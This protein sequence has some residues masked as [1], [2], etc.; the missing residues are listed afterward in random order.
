ML[1]AVGGSC[2]MVDIDG[3]RA[4]GAAKSSLCSL[5]LLSGSL[6]GVHRKILVNVS[7]SLRSLKLLEKSLGL[8]VP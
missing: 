6:L 1:D 4:Q 7:N 8:L 2:E 5:W 3:V